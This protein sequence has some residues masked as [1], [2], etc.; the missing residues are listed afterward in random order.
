MSLLALEQFGLALARS[1]PLYNRSPFTDHS[2]KQ[3][4]RQTGI[5]FVRTMVSAFLGWLPTFEDHG[6]CY[7]I[8][9]DSNVGFGGDDY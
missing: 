5:K 3:S 1:R 8:V 9:L 4:R 2:Y 6:E 7:A